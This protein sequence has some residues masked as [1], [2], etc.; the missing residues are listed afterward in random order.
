[1]SLREFMVDY[2]MRFV[3]KPYIWGGSGVIGFDCSGLVQECLAAVGLD[4]KGDQT[5][6]GLR[7][8]FKSKTVHAPDIGVLAFFGTKESATHVALCIGNG[9]MLEAGGGGKAC[10][11]IKS[12]N[13]LGAMV[14][15]RALTN[16]NDL[17]CFCDPFIT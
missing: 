15:V 16:R 2:G 7:I 10:V 14:R 11:D 17:I 13:N 12:A 5:A 9:L 1:M 3:G 6:N 4:P 8:A